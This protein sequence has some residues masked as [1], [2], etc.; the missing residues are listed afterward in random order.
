MKPFFAI[1]IDWNP[2]DSEDESHRDAFSIRKS[3]AR[4]VKPAPTCFK[5]QE[6][7]EAPLR[8]DASNVVK[9][10]TSCIERLGGEAGWRLPGLIA[11][12]VFDLSIRDGLEEQIIN[13]TEIAVDGCS[14]EFLDSLQKLIDSE[15]SKAKRG[16]KA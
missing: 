6:K 9:C 16:P 7:R 13:M 2:A 14:D 12:I 8:D 5:S 1:R 11:D 15:K 3:I 4:Q 10:I